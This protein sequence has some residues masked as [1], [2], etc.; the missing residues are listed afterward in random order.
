MKDGADLRFLR[1]VVDPKSGAI[2]DTK[3][4]E[5]V[6]KLQNYGQCNKLHTRTK[7]QIDT[8]LIPYILEIFLNR[9]GV[10]EGVV[11]TPQTAKHSVTAKIAQAFGV[12]S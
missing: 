6:P 8:K 1:P 12:A 10:A 5:N 2:R 4:S 11:R 7:M 3:P 9:K